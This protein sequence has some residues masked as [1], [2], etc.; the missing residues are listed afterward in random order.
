MKCENCGHLRTEGYEYPESYC[1]LTI[2][3]DD[4][5]ILRAFDSGDGCTL[6]RQQRIELCKE[7]EHINH[8]KLWWREHWEK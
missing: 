3:D 2:S 4:G 5:N 7:I 6:T 1:E 8:E